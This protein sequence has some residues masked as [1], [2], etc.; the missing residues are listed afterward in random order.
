MLQK[1]RTKGRYF[2]SKRIRKRIK[3]IRVLNENVQ[4][5]FS[6]LSTKFRK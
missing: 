2:S 4:R 3:K 6:P 1:N 5:I